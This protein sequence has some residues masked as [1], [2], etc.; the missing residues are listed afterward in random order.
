MHLNDSDKKIVTDAITQKCGAMRC[1]CCGQN[2]WTLIDIPTIHIGFNTHTTRFHY[3][4][5]IPVVY[6][7]C[8]NCGHLVPFSAVMLGLKPDVPPVTS[9]PDPG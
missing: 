1:F 6:V 7:A 2:Q 8:S 5:G 3:H 9:I 4:D